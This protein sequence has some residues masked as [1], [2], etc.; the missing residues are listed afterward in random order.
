M[1]QLALANIEIFLKSRSEDYED[2]FEIGHEIEV[3]A[4]VSFPTRSRKT[5]GNKQSRARHNKQ[6]SFSEFPAHLRCEIADAQHWSATRRYKFSG[7][8]LPE[9]TRA[10][11][12]GAFLEPEELERERR[13]YSLRV[14]TSE[15]APGSYLLR[16]TLPK[17]YFQQTSAMTALNERLRREQTNDDDDDDDDDEVAAE[18]QKK[19]KEAHRQLL[20]ASKKE[21]TVQI[22][23]TL[24][25]VRAGAHDVCFRWNAKALP[26]KVYESVC[27]SSRKSSSAE[28]CDGETERGGGWKLAL[29]V[30]P[31]LRENE[32]LSDVVSDAFVF[33]AK[34]GHSVWVVKGSRIMYEISSR[35]LMEREKIISFPP[36]RRG[37]AV[38]LAA[39]NLDNSDDE[40]SEPA[41][42]TRRVWVSANGLEVSASC[43]KDIREFA[44]G[45]AKYAPKRS[46]SGT[47]IRERLEDLKPPAPGKDEVSILDRRLDWVPKRMNSDVGSSTASTSS[48]STW[49]RERGVNVLIFRLSDGAIEHDVT[50]DTIG[51]KRTDSN[52]SR[53]ACEALKLAFSPSDGAFSKSRDGQRILG[54]RMV[55]I[56]T[57]GNWASNAAESGIA[58]VLREIFVDRFGGDSQLASRAISDAIGGDPKSASSI[59]MIAICEKSAEPDVFTSRFIDAAV[60]KGKEQ[61]ASIKIRFGFASPDGWFPTLSNS[62]NSGRSGD[63]KI[64]LKRCENS[65]DRLN[66]GSPPSSA[67]MPSNQS[68]SDDRS[69]KKNIWE[70]CGVWAEQ[71]D[72]EEDRVAGDEMTTT[73]V[74]ERNTGKNYIDEKDV[75]QVEDDIDIILNELEADLKDVTVTA[76]KQQQQQHNARYS[77]EDER[78]ESLKL[79]A[80]VETLETFIFAQADDEERKN[81]TSRDSEIV[82]IQP[83]YSVQS[84]QL[85]FGGEYSHSSINAA[86]LFLTL[87]AFARRRMQRFNWDALKASSSNDAPAQV[88]L[89]IEHWMRETSRKRESEYSAKLACEFIAAGAIE[90]LCDRILNLINVDGSLISE[91]QQDDA[92]TCIRTLSAFCL[93]DNGAHLAEN[94]RRNALDAML[95]SFLAS[96]NGHLGAD[97]DT[98]PLVK[99]ERVVEWLA[100][101]DL[102]TCNI[103]IASTEVKYASENNSG[104]KHRRKNSSFATSTECFE[105]SCLRAQFPAMLDHNGIYGAPLRIIELEKPSEKKFDGLI[106]LPNKSKRKGVIP[107]ASQLS[108]LEAKALS[109]LESG[110]L[111]EIDN[112][113][114]APVKKQERVEENSDDSEN[115]WQDIAGEHLSSSDST[116][117]SDEAKVSQ[118]W[119]RGAVIAIK[120]KRNNWDDFCEIMRQA[121][122]LTWLLESLGAKAVLFVFPTMKSESARE[123]LQPLIANPNFETA[124]LKIPVF[125]VPGDIFASSHEGAKA[126]SR[127]RHQLFGE[128]SIIRV[129]IPSFEDCPNGSTNEVARRLRNVLVFALKDRE[130]D[131]EIYDK[132]PP[133]GGVLV[134]RC[135]NQWNNPLSKDDLSSTASNLADASSTQFDAKLNRKFRKWRVAQRIVNALGSEDLGIRAEAYDLDEDEDTP[136]RVLCMDGGGMRGYCTIV[137]LKRILEATGA[138]CLG[139][140]F[141]LIVGTSTGGI[142]AL[143]AG[144]LR[145]TV[146]ELDALYEQMAKDVFK[147]DSYVS[148]LTKGP[149]H[150]AAKSFENVLQNVLGE[151]PDAELYTVG[152]HQRWFRS[153]VPPPRV[154]L[155]S[156]LVS[157]NPSSLYMHRSYRRE[158]H[159]PSIVASS[160]KMKKSELDYAGDF[161]IGMSAALR[162]TT[163]APW[164]ME[165][166]ICDKELGYG[167]VE[168]SEKVSENKNGGGGGD[169]DDDDDDNEKTKDKAKSG[170]SQGTA[171]NKLRPSDGNSRTQLR[172]IDGAI[173]CNNPAAAAVFEAKRIFNPKR[174]LVLVSVGTGYPIPRDVPASIGA[175]WV[176]NVVNATCDVIQVD[177]TIRHVLDEQRDEYFRFQPQGEIFSCALND[178][179]ADAQKKLKQT[180]LRYVNSAKQRCEIDR[181]A[182]LLRKS[183]KILPRRR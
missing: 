174:P 60:S 124:E 112:R 79:R 108:P 37:Y 114:P 30:Q 153:F 115:D 183:R 14:S 70:V 5:A 31:A 54:A 50:F 12:A 158:N 116:K 140:V 165:E 27:G 48:V 100:A 86:P 36:S 90:Y 150:V 56:T 6:I 63:G 81:K 1:S 13:I 10:E 16:C 107:R 69:Q 71:K 34:A 137:M 131:K 109:R 180:A 91:I 152:A 119:Y 8:L 143:G 179:S 139:E 35:E 80:V 85:S 172:F 169:D 135:Y 15:F 61:R 88:F 149:G 101:N 129:E 145:M 7:E 171:L 154:V 178:T 155:V 144:L 42:T 136:V 159:S 64:V 93:R 3:S 102:R 170:T 151:D 162:A 75:N 157:R 132:T 52:A 147:P 20:I 181:L 148:L 128:D 55:L 123:A 41:V 176:Q 182:F 76:I 38:A 65:A 4:T 164:Y 94:V 78:L 110:W 105:F 127:R 146:V 62:A 45:D 99:L 26:T 53:A 39:F 18:D 32:K 168:M 177:A 67:N 82:K 40:N 33:A 47:V 121:P 46:T 133:E 89:R 43:T 97:L 120:A 83:N 173:S 66:S 44:V 24:E 125:V 113:M 104:T 22:A 57:C 9:P 160:S 111:G 118:S 17:D 72:D 117:D 51:S 28:E 92:R 122:R 11:P 21:V 130:S 19:R 126:E 87:I 163:A 98:P 134:G 84:A 29:D 96:W 58:D 73:T 175:Q 49:Q 156:S 2:V 142:I 141:D 74:I 106:Q 77:A 59:C 103:T 95:R 166:L 25:F 23:P 68:I 167:S 161:R 138:W